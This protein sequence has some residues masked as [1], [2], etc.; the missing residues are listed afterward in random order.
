MT[1]L[2]R[3]I[4]LKE[5]GYTY[6]YTTGVIKNHKGKEITYKQNKG[7]IQLFLFTA[8]KEYQVLGH[9]FGWFYYYGTQPPK[10]LDHIDRN[11]LNN[12]IE[13]LRE[14]THQENLFN[15]KAKGYTYDKKKNMYCAQL[16]LDGKNLHLGCYGTTEEARAAY[17]EGKNKYH[18]IN[19]RKD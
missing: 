9:R 14:T 11:P 1:E 7:Y 12:R 17:L 4:F 2:E 13:N 15:Q 8:G 5:K 19:D 16:Y 6:D 18:K 3:M 10:H